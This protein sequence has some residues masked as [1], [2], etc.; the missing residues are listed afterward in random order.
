MKNRQALTK[1]C[2]IL[3]VALA[4]PA[5]IV[6]MTVVIGSF[7]HLTGI[8]FGDRGVSVSGVLTDSE[9]RP[10][11]GASIELAPTRESGMWEQPV[12]SM[13]D[14]NGNY[15]CAMMSSPNEAN[16]AFFLRIRKTGY[17]DYRETIRDR[18]ESSHNVI[19]LNEN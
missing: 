11:A 16:P 5:F 15:S 7:F 10:I 8:S 9:G 4:Y 3:S 17:R 6:F 14:E 2:V 18:D 1:L 13:S 12:H 19:L